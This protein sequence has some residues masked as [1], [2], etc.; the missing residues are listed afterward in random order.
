[1]ENLVL[2]KTVLY[3][4]FSTQVDCQLF[5]FLCLHNGT[6][7]TVTLLIYYF[8]PESFLFFRLLHQSQDVFVLF[9]E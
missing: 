9:L 8:N 7:P 4:F 3:F 5:S 2:L 1:M 6:L